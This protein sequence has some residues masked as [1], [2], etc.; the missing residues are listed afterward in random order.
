MPQLLASAS[1]KPN[2]TSDLGQ[3][4][5]WNTKTWQTERDFSM[6]DDAGP[7]A[8]AFRPDGLR[9]AAA[10]H[11]VDVYCPRTGARIRTFAE[12]S[13]FTGLAFTSRGDLFTTH[14]DGTVR[15]YHL[16]LAEEV[17]PTAALV[18]APLG[19]AGLL[20]AWQATTGTSS[21]MMSAHGSRA[22]CVAAD[23]TGSYLA[24]AGLDGLIKFWDARTLQPL[25]TIEGHVGGVHSLAFDPSGRFLASGGKDATIRIWNAERR[26]VLALRGHADTVWA[27]GFSADGRYLASGGSDKTVKVWDI[28]PLLEKAKR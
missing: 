20:R 27:L 23:P 18:T 21:Q 1:F 4:K 11:G 5:L 24:S 8:V 10:I 7:V 25:G 15:K 26:E 17:G 19:M 9:L 12:S 13:F 16:S 28:Q 3:L 2:E 14:V 6:E 22:S